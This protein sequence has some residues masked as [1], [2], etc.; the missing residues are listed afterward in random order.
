MAGYGIDGEFV[1]DCYT[2]I[3]SGQPESSVR[4]TRRCFGPGPHE[5]QQIF[6][7]MERQSTAGPFQILAVRSGHCIGIR[8]NQ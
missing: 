5:F 4:Q 7:P 3:R 8:A 6:I 1:I 2:I